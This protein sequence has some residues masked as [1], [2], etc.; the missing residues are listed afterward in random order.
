M[1]RR[2]P[3]ELVVLRQPNARQ[4]RLRPHAELKFE[5]VGGGCVR[6]DRDGLYVMPDEVM[7]DERKRALEKASKL[8]DY[9]AV[10]ADVPLD[11]QAEARV[12]LSAFIRCFIRRRD[13]VPVVSYMDGRIRVSASVD[14]VWRDEIELFCLQLPF[15]HGSIQAREGKV[16]IQTSSSSSS[17]SISSSASLDSGTK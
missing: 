13:Q 11:L 16:E 2:L 6:C 4:V 15:I 7:P 17:H 14:R 12:L 5:E 1:K 9:K 8:P 10:I 3:L